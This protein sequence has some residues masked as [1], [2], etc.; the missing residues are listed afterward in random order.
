L[1]HQ[2][3]H[4]INGLYPICERNVEQ[5]EHE[6]FTVRSVFEQGVVAHGDALQRAAFGSEPTLLRQKLYE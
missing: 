3:R 1:V 2:Q 6:G 5:R 4:L